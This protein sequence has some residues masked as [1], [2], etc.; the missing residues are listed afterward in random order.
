[1]QS[2]DGAVQSCDLV[3]NEHKCTAALLQ[4][5]H[6]VSRFGSCTMRLCTSRTIT[7]AP[8]KTE[9]MFDA[10][11][12]RTYC[13]STANLTYC[14]FQINPSLFHTHYTLPSTFCGWCTIQAAE[15]AS[16]C[17]HVSVGVP[18]LHFV[19]HLR[20]V[21]LFEYTMRNITTS[22]FLSAQLKSQHYVGNVLARGR[23]DNKLL[24]WM[25]IFTKY[26]RAVGVHCC[27]RSFNY[28]DASHINQLPTGT[29]FYFISRGPKR[30]K[31]QT[32]KLKGH[33]AEKQFTVWSTST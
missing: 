24:L 30:I 33:F 19:N 28:S 20:F 4:Q 8:I 23:N 25:S 15:N 13:S 7:L 31:W 14:W 12:P 11:R 18:R 26:T 1:M 3:T 10:C 17:Y 6:T 27:L 21:S 5:R 9:R 2:R 29:Y 22:D 16:W 32:E